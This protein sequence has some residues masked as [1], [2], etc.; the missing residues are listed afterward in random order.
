[1]N[2]RR[3]NT[4]ISGLCGVCVRVRG[5]TVLAGAPEGAH[6][7]HLMH[8]FEPIF[9]NI[10]SCEAVFAASPYTACVY[11]LYTPQ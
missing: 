10:I 1:M 5:R 3:K 7:S 8:I 6:R 4:N 9:S 11:Q 2:D